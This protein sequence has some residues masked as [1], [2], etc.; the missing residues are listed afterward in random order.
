MLIDT[1]THRMICA[2]DEKNRLSRQTIDGVAIDLTYTKYD[3]IENK[4]FGGKAHPLSVLRYSYDKKGRIVRKTQDGHEQ[5]FVYDKKGQL[6]QVRD[7]EGKIVEE[8]AYDKAGNVAWKKEGEVLVEYEYDRANQLV[9]SRKRGETTRY[10]YDAA[11][12]M[13]REGSRRYRYEGA[14]KVKAVLEGEQEL[15]RYDYWA[16]GQLA[17]AEGID[18]EKEDFLWDGLALIRRGAID[19]LNE[20]SPTGGNPVASTGKVLFNDL[21][22]TTLAAKGK[23]KL[24]KMPVSAFGAASDVGT[25]QFFTGKPY[26]QGLGYAYLMRNYRADLGKWQ[27]ADPLGYPDGWNAFAYCNNQVT[28]HFDFL[29]GRN[30]LHIQF[31]NTD[32]I[33]VGDWEWVGGKPTRVYV[34]DRDLDGLPCHYYEIRGTKVRTV[35]LR[36]ETKTYDYDIF[37]K[38]QFLEDYGEMIQFCDGDSGTG[39]SGIKSLTI[40]IATSGEYL[41]NLSYLGTYSSKIIKEKEYRSGIIIPDYVPIKE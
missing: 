5:N 6:V 33:A 37:M 10:E 2:Y 21:L 23:D 14:D 22:G 18:G 9:S 30:Y 25:H 35:F 41:K 34:D 7:G 3:Q 36:T 28:D 17:R 39:Q 31:I 29:G 8:Y 11:G 26:V 12:R 24:E 4:Y 1:G 32:P 16:D 15:M 40:K 27:T 13:V 19:Y 20:P 38:G